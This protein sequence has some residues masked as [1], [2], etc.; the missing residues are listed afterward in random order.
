MPHSSAVIRLAVAGALGRTGSRVLARALEDPRFDV[1]AALLP[2]GDPRAGSTT[3]VDRP[4]PLRDALVDHVD[5]LIDLTLPA[6]TMH[7]L[8]RCV[9]RGI[10]LVTGTTGLSEEQAARVRQ[11]AGRIPIVRSSNFSVGVTALVELVERLARTLGPD[12]DIELVEAHHRHK[13][14]A[15]SGTARLFLDA[16]RRAQDPAMPPDVVHGRHGIT[17]ERP[18]GQIGVHALRMGEIVGQHEIHFCSAGETIT[19]RH[20]AL[21]RDAF[22]E[23]ALRAAAWVIGRP[24]GFY[25]MQQVLHT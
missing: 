21:S 6:G 16:L 1:R 19:L 24:P 12:Y 9:E 25:S 7:W 17:G 22:A 11:A 10:A 8:D 20:A 3:G 14:D 23:G 18:R 4:V 5:V 13:A 15:P 2:E